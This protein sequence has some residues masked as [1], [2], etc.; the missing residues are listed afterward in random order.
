[1]EFFLEQLGGAEIKWETL[2]HNGVLFPPPYQPHKVPVIYQGRSIVLDPESEELATMYA[3]YIGSEYVNNRVFNKNFWNEWK[4]VLGPNHVIKDLAGVDF[5]LINQYLIDQKAVSKVSKEE[6]EREAEHYKYA[7]VDGRKEAVG[8]FRIE[9][10]GIFLGRGCNPNLGKIKR[11][12]YPE[13]VIINIG[14]DADV[15]KVQGH[16]WKEVVH[17]HTS[18]WLAS[19]KDLITGKTKY[20]WLANSSEFKK[21][22]DMSK[23][24]L[25]R[26]LKRKIKGIRSSNSELMMNGTEIQKQ[27]AVAF[28]FIDQF[29]LRVGNEKGKS[30]ADTVGVTTLRVEHVTLLGDRKVK[31]D[32]LGKDSVRYNRILEVPQVVYENL[33]QMMKGKEKKD[34]LFDLVNS[35]MINRYLEGYMPGLTSKVFRTFNASYLY[36]KELKKIDQKMKDYDKIDKV[37]VLLDEMNKANAKVAMLCNHQKNVSASLKD[38]V[39]KIDESIKIAKKK[40]RDLKKA[41]KPNKERIERAQIALKKLRAR[42]EMKVQL[43][44]ISLGTSK[45]NYIDPRITIAFIKRHQIPIDKVFTKTLQEKFKWAQELADASFVF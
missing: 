23:F 37:S 9:P 3:K 29:A 26:K 14:E 43:K 21:D 31:L 22:S 13:D 27:L 35:Q 8:N 10:P 41:K 36:A 2:S 34:N 18:V 40:T 44:N 4:K 42:K 5:G 30:Q 33:E 38:Q 1:M 24:D 39:G 28:Y 11:R 20:V 6:K 32:F 25:A 17:D 12:V 15:P 45:V 7:M 16:R 19:W